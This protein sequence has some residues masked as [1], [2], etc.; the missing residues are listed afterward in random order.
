MKKSNPRKTR[1]KENIVQPDETMSFGVIQFARFGKNII[2][3]SNWNGDQHTE[4]LQR[5]AEQHNDVVSEID[6]LVKSII[7][8]VQALPPEKLLHRAWTEMFMSSRHIEVE[9]DVRAKDALAMRMIDYIQSIIAATPP[10][11]TQKSEVSQEDWDHLSELVDKLFKKINFEYPVCARAKRKLSTEQHDAE[12]EDFQFKAQLH[13]CNVRGNDY[14]IHQVQ[15]IADLIT[16]QSDLIEKRFQISAA[17]LI[18]SMQKIWHSLIYGIND[19]FETV[20]KIRLATCDEMEKI[21][22]DSTLTNGKNMHE[23]LQISLER[24]GCKDEFE[25]GMSTLFGMDLFDVGLLTNLPNDFLDEFSWSPGQDT[26]FLAPGEFSG[27]P[28]RVW[29]IFKRPFIKISNRYYCF[30]ASC[31]FDNFYRQIEKK[32]YTTSEKEK[33]QWIATRKVVSE[34]L[35]IEYLKKLMPSATVYQEAYY[36]YQETPKSKINW[37]E[38]DSLIIYNDHLF[39]VEVKAGAFTY[40]SPANDLPA[41]ISS[42]KSLVQSPSQQG[43]RFLKYLNSSD[44]VAIFDSNNGNNIATIKKSD[45]RHITICAITLDVFTEIAAQAQHL[46]KIGVEIGSNLIWPISLSDLRVY[47]DIFTNSLEFLHFIENRIRANS[48]KHL[49]LN[50][51]LDHLGLY[52]EHNNYAMHAD[53]IHNT[54]ATG[55]FIFNGYRSEIDRF[56]STVAQERSYPATPT[57]KMPSRLREAIDFL[58]NSDLPL[59]ALIASYLL[60][61]GGDWREQLFNWVEDEINIIPARGR[62]VPV[63]THGETRLTIFVGISGQ[64]Q[65][66]RDLALRHAKTVMVGVQEIDRT[67]LLLHYSEKGILNHLDYT[68]LNAKEISPDELENFKIAAEQLKEKRIIQSRIQLG[69]IGRNEPCPC[70][71]GKKYKRCCLN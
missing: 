18:Q 23:L 6:T 15:A 33:Q 59:R 10:N 32:I 52:L 17:L 61:L 47:S 67:I 28:L 58:D 3:K 30:D 45:F 22:L 69:K 50:D 27:W 35:P 16:P 34:N 31:L 55:T 13:W 19:A 37:C 62:C 49:E 60:D 63:S 54:Y 24:L 70:G 8:I 21:K 39:L 20:D 66:N 40:T 51:E 68:L 38:A 64:T 12:M 1:T 57:Q 46:N 56:L 65:L 36:P 4:M 2:A 41:Y 11:A 44:E 26:E 7:L 53:E 9:A 14:Q 42:I 43:L 48:S 25:K 29:P 71:S 5:C